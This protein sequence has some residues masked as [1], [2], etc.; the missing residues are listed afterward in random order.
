MTNAEKDYAIRV[1]NLTMGWPRKVLLENVS[2]DIPTGQ[3]VFLLGGSGCGKSSLMK[4]L[5]GLNAPLAGDIKIQGRSIVHSPQE[6]IHEIQRSLGIMYQ[7]GALFGSMSVL[8]NVR[9]PL[10]HFTD[11]SEESKDLTCKLVLNMLEMQHAAYLMPGELS[12]GMLK[13]AGI[14]RAMV[15]GA[16]IVLLD[17]PGAGLDPI[18]AAN[19]DRTILRLR[20]SLGCTF[21]I[22]SHEL[23]SIF[24]IAD[25]CLM[26][27]PVSKSII[28]DGAPQELR[29]HSPNPRVKQFF[30]GAPDAQR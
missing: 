15:L 8:D 25:R 13:R 16:K 21:I 19:L 3:I 24:S 14:A 20:D 11:L 7:S 18:T 2:F 26:L 4:T 22:V 30:N 1:E 27:D 17:E 28:A 9:F 10:D 6:E 23:Q 12:G 5:I 29:D